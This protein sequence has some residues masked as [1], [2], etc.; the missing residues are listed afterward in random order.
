[1]ER[2]LASC[3]YMCQSLRSRHGARSGD[4]APPEVAP[5]PERPQWHV[6]HFPL[7]IL[8]V[9]LVLLD[10][11]ETV[12][13]LYDFMWI[14]WRGALIAG[15]VFKYATVC[16]F[17]YLA[18][19]WLRSQHFQQWRDYGRPIEL[20][21]YAHRMARDLLTSALILVALS[22]F[23]LLNN[24]NLRCCPGFSVHH[25]LIYRDPGRPARENLMFTPMKQ[26]PRRFGKSFWKS[27]LDRSAKSESDVFDSEKSDF[28]G[29]RTDPSRDKTEM[30]ERQKT[31]TKT[32]PSEAEGLPRLLSSSPPMTGGEGLP[33][34]TSPSSLHLEMTTEGDIEDSGDT[35]GDIELGL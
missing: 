24:L 6:R 5:Q 4:S 13:A 34:V 29:N 27:D 22:P 15:F 19:E 8:A 26:G 11:A 10:T 28:T 25:L 18:E 21:V 30:S 35:E 16:A 23:V 12:A 3:S 9:L 2:G 33:K 7:V 20:L 1:M 31:R 32:F 14:E 17:L